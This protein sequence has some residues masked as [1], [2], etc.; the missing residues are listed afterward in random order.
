MSLALAPK[1][2]KAVGTS[3]MAVVTGF[4]V[5]LRSKAVMQKKCVE[6]GYRSLPKKI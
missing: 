6:T 4:Q 2:A 3:K 5:L 1:K